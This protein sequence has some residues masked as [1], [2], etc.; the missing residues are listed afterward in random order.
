MFKVISFID[1]DMW[2]LT[3]VKINKT[4]FKKASNQAGSLEQVKILEEVNI[5]TNICYFEFNAFSF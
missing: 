1:P 4:H 5:L 3:A 2:L